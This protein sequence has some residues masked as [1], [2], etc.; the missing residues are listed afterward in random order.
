MSRNH[1]KSIHASG[2]A[3]AGLVLLAT[4]MATPAAQA[5]SATQFKMVRSQNLPK[6]CA[7]HAVAHVSIKSLGFAEQMT[8]TA[9]GLPP[10]TEFDAFVIQVPNFPF[11]VSWYVGDLETNWK[12]VAKKTFISRFSRET[13]AVAPNVAPAPK[14]DRADA[15][16]NPAFRPIHTLHLGIWFNSPKDAQ[17]AGCPN[18]VTPFN[19]EHDAG[20]QILNTRTFQDD[21][22]PLGRID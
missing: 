18:I 4:A 5:D 9:A 13:F 11:G 17:K 6:K 22:G 16:K 8:I 2:I 1:M 21:K 7:P 14:V 3:L 19:G 15:D 12:G 20:P 10:R